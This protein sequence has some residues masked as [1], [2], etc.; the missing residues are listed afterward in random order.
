MPQ[1]TAF[2]GGHRQ[3]SLGLGA[4][5]QG[6]IVRVT[7]SV[8][9]QTLVST[10]ISNVSRSTDVAS[11]VSLCCPAQTQSLRMADTPLLAALSHVYKKQFKNENKQRH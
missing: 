11:L 9:A 3:V 6:P 1:H 10:C 2:A 4:L 8:T 5:D 7:W